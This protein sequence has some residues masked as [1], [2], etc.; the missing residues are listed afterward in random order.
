MRSRY[1]AYVTGNID[2][3]AA[4]HDPATAATFDRAAAARWAAEADWKRLQIVATDNDSV[5]FI[6]WFD[7]GGRLRRHHEHSR[8]RRIG[9]AWY[10]S[11]GTIKSTDDQP[12]KIGR[13]DPCPC[14][15]G[16]K[17]KKCHAD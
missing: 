6:A 8:F 15:S 1:S 16:R 14:G 10:Y 17:Y 11:E 4:T 2:Y 13:N 3:L 5:E 9:D 7:T 12:I